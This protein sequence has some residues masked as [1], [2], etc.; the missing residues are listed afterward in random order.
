MPGHP[1]V[2]VYLNGLDISG[3]VVEGDWGLA[4][5]SQTA[6][7]VIYRLWPP[8]HFHQADPN[9]FPRTG[10]APQYGRREIDPGPRPLQPAE[11]YHRSWG[12]ESAPTP[13]TSPTQYDMPPVIV[14]PDG[15]APRPRFRP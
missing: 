9:Y 12:V 7:T 14:A 2:P 5:P 3:A 6:P 11:S 4:R 8:Q 13:A 10:R 15:R 1:G